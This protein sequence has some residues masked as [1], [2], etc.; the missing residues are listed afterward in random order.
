MAKRVRLTDDV[1]KAA[2]CPPGKKDVLIFDAALRGFALRVT[3]AGGRG[4]LLQYTVAGVRRRATIGEWGVLTTAQARAKAEALRG[5]VAEKRDPT[6]ERKQRLAEQRAA[7]ATAKAEQ[8]RA[9]FTVE[10]LIEQW[11]ALHLAERSASYGRRA[12][13]DLRASLRAWLVAP[14]ASLDHAATVALLDHVRA[15]RGP[16]AANRLRAMARACW[17]WATRRGSLPANP[18]AATPRP[19]AE[20]A[21]ER[22]LSDAELADLWRISATLPHPWF[23]FL[24]L[25]ILT[26][27]RRGEVAA[28]A[29]AELDLAAAE[30]RL[31][32]VRAKNHRAH[33]VPLSPA[34][35]AVLAEVPRVAGQSLVF[36]NARGTPPSGFGRLTDR[37]EAAMQ[38]AAAEAGRS[39]PPWTLHDLRRTVATGLQRLGVRLEVTE[40]L[41]NHVSGSR[42][43]IVGVYQRHGWEPEKRAALEAWAG[44]VL[45]CAEAMPQAEDGRV[46][47]LVERRERRA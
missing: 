40:A 15:E 22:V 36:G 27:Q 3:A 33:T 11:A 31:P 12:P 16:I 35:L 32:A 43:G 34:A 7:E 14:A 47:A 5:Q 21:R 29:W 39:C 17:T 4:F 25:L 26:G 45:R 9:A 24:R 28:L 41:L 30:W 23:G 18:W 38:E 6:A 19:A 8:A 42:S 46:V 20:R 37:L 10:A 13:A 44:H 2:T 1:A